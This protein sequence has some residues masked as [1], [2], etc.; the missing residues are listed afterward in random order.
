MTESHQRFG[1]LLKEGIKRVQIVKDKPIGVILDEFGYELRPEDSSKGRYALGHWYYKKR[2]PAEMSDV[3][4]LARLIVLNSDVDRQWLMHFLESAGHP[5]V[6]RYCNQFFVAPSNLQ[7]VPEQ[8]QI[9]REAEEAPS[10]GVDL[11]HPAGQGQVEQK[12]QQGQRR[13]GPSRWW[14]AGFIVLGIITIALL[15]M[16]TRHPT[17]QPA[18]SATP[19]KS[20]A[21][22]IPT[23]TPM[24]TATQTGLPNATPAIIPTL[25]PTPISTTIPPTGTPVVFDGRCPAPKTGLAFSYSSENSFTDFLDQGGSPYILRTEFMQ[26]LASI[27]TLRGGQIFIGD[28]TGDGVDEV[29]IGLQL[30]PGSTMQVLACNAGSYQTLWRRADVSDEVIKAVTRLNNNDKADLINYSVTDGEYAPAY[31]YSVL[32]WNG[33]DF[34]EL[35]D[36]QWFHTIG[37]SLSTDIGPWEL[38][39]PN[40]TVS[41]TDTNADSVYDIVITGGL[42]ALVPNCNTVF[43]RQFTDT[44][45][46]DGSSYQFSD[47]V[48]IPPL[49]RFQSNADGDLAFALREYDRALDSYQKTIFDA[50]LQPRSWFPP[51]LEYCGR[52]GAPPNTTL[53]AEDETQLLEAYARWRILLIQTIQGH[54][55]AMQVVYDT[56]EQKYP[57]GKTGYTYAFIA[58][59]FWETYQLTSDGEAACK[60]AN[61][62][63]QSLTLYPGHKPELICLWP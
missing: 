39:I 30:N 15:S 62:A 25:T 53:P 63:A 28:L 59:Q 35:M 14:L 29:V 1:E 13:R 9:I 43:Q 8:P 49:Y 48:Y 44:W 31:Q 55:D 22:D 45:V 52:I 37:E 12:S 10:P 54:R 18:S 4:M 41:I 5:D 11:P 24:Q 34:R 33:G 38:S 23:G 57:E 26:Q 56:L 60:Q 51:A 7:V 61:Q 32:E 40:A 6:A 36:P 17:D 16:F 46:W 19:V 20:G 21:I 50:G 3:E 47:R 42:E 58:K 2:I 27:E